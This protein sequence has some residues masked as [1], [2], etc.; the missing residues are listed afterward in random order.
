MFA[1]SADK[2][3]SKSGITKPGEVLEKASETLMGCFRVC[4]ADM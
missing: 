2:V 3:Q 4:V 1:I